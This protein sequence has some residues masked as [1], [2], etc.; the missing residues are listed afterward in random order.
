LRRL[1][2]CPRKK[3]DPI[4][5]VLSILLEYVRKG[6][7][8]G[9]FVEIPERFG[10]DAFGNAK[11]K[12]TTIVI[13]VEYSPREM[14][15]QTIYNAGIATSDYR[16]DLPASFARVIACCL[17]Y[18]PQDRLQSFAEL[19]EELSSIVRQEGMCISAPKETSASCGPYASQGFNLGSMAMSQ[20]S[21]SQV[22]QALATADR[23]I[24]AEPDNSLLWITKGN[25]L[26]H[27]GNHLDAKACFTKAIRLSPTEPTAWIPAVAVSLLNM[28]SSHCAFAVHMQPRAIN[29]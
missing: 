13:R 29:L 3:I 16:D 27:I 14:E 2:L 25:A 24:A 10:Y 7:L 1:L 6:F 15:R 17:E 23:A 8:P 26:Q 4:D 9:F 19:E 28:R 5:D 20:V 18:D 21:L 12:K 11:L 22:Q